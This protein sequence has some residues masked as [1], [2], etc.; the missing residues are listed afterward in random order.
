[1]ASY[2]T[3]TSTSY[4][5]SPPTW[6]ANAPGTLKSV[7]PQ[8]GNLP[9][10][11]L[12]KPAPSDPNTALLDVPKPD[13]PQHNT[14]QPIAPQ[15]TPIP[16]DPSPPQRQPSSPESLVLADDPYNPPPISVGSET[17]SAVPA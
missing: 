4:R 7:S 2:L 12:A 10:P 1:M 14:D 11:A 8:Q 16:G 17:L 13:T 15:P 9:A 3:D 6:V 5:G